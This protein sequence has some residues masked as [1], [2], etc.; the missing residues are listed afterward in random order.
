[1]LHAQL[2]QGLARTPAGFLPI[3]TCLSQREARQCRRHILL[4]KGEIWI[5]A[6][7]ACRADGYHAR[8]PCRPSSVSLCEK[9]AV[10][11]PLLRNC[12]GPLFLRSRERRF[13][14][15]R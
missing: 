8:E 5:E 3:P 12:A 9:T 15:T 11:E 4:G 2:R 10:L 7:A 13:E 6:H 1:R 14:A